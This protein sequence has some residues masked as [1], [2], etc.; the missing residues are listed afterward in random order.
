MNEILFVVRQTFDSYTVAM[1]VVIL[2]LKK[3]IIK[4]VCIL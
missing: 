2:I 4:E 3:I 1:A